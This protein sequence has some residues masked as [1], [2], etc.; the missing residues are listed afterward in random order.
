M[1]HRFRCFRPACLNQV[2]RG[3]VSASVVVAAVQPLSSD[4]SELLRSPGWLAVMPDD[5]QPLVPEVRAKGREW[6]VDST[7]GD[8][9]GAGSKASPWKTL[10]RLKRAALSLGDVVRLRC[11][12]VWRETLFIDGRSLPPGLTIA[13]EEGCATG[14]S[15]SIR[16]SDV[17]EVA[18]GADAAAKGGF[19]TDRF[20]AASA[21]FYKGQRMQPARMPDAGGPGQEFLLADGQN[22]RRSF[23]V[24]DAERRQIGDR[25]LVGATAYVRA[26]P[27]QVEKAVVTSYDPASGVLTLDKELTSNILTGA[28]FILE[29]KR[30]MMN[31][32]GE[33]FH[34]VS[35]KRLS[36]LPP[37][38]QMPKP[39]DVEVASRDHAIQVRGGQQLRVLGLD[40]RQ[41]AGVALD[42]Q[43][44]RESVFEGLDFTYPGEY[45]VVIDQSNGVTLK[46]S[47]VVASGW[48]SIMTRNAPDCVVNGNLVIDSGLLGR[49]V[50]SGAAI[51][52]NG[53]RN[54]VTHNVVLRAANAGI[55]FFN[56]EGT[57]VVDNVVIQPCARL[58]DCGGIYTWTGHSPSLAIRKRTTRSTVKN[59]VVLGGA[60]NLE[61]TAGRGRNQSVGVYLDEMTGGVQVLSNVLVGM[62]NGVYLHNAQFND[63]ADNT[64]RAVTHASITAHMSLPDQDVI[65][66][67]RFRNN[68]LVSRPPARGGDEVFAFKWQQRADPD[69]LFSG[70][71]A[72]LVQDN[73]VV[74][75]GSEGRPRWLVGEGVTTRALAP[76]DWQK[77]AA[78][79]REQ[80]LKLA[81][82]PA[83]TFERADVGV[84]LDGDMRAKPSPWTPYFNP[85]GTGG[86]AAPM[87]CDGVP[88]MR[89]VPGHVGDVLSSK[90]FK[91]SARGGKNNHLLRYTVKAGPKGATIRVTVRR[92]GPPYESFGL[93]QAPLKLNPGQIFKAELP[94]EA[95]SADA[96]RVDFS[97]EPGS[98]VFL[99][100]VEVAQVAAMSTQ[101]ITAARS[102]FL[103]NLTDRP[104]DISCADTGMP[105]CS[106]VDDA[107][108][109]VKW[110]L[111]LAP[112]KGVAVFPRQ[113]GN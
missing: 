81:P 83:R 98:E 79:E 88:C 8:D 47:R 7:K 36:F 76:G 80:V 14:K 37:D 30:W 66:G 108:R 16:G 24:R 20:G 18:W 46:G 56:K 1:V 49:A 100:Q 72:N 33:W 93:D 65:R 35:T 63:I 94:F 22:S 113:P 9:S 91:M 11:G 29:G 57:S 99:S 21:L 31:A 112:R 3:L 85:A 58:A 84:V 54:L 32:K 68:T 55:T 42:V 27:W 82:E 106:A 89:F 96:A 45:A 61:G 15:P 5:S 43:F 105:D 10:G 48:S 60:S 67:N 97:G 38:G 110:P 73:E 28:G 109:E 13:A 4:A 95:T 74:Q 101:R 87:L 102:L 50:G 92:N 2:L 41:T 64:V 75:A 71:D 107:G 78:R 6:F 17:V 111:A 26:V 44:T 59:N 86:L 19:V 90:S 77:F 70:D 104:R 25:E 39:G 62:E 103:V 53:E 69:R 12:S 52:A 40:L 23:R 51:I 34:D